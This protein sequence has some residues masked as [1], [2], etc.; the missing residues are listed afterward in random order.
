MCSSASWLS[1]PRSGR[2]ER[3]GGGIATHDADLR[4]ETHQAGEA[5]GAGRPAGVE[6]DRDDPAAA[7]AGQEARGPAQPGAEVEHARAGVDAGQAGEG[8]HRGQ[9]AVVILVELE[10]IVGGDR[11]VGERARAGAA[12][13]APG[14]R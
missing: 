11:R 7:P 9:A 8:V 10:E 6:L 3:Q 14:S 5:G 2:G 13:R 12:R 1:T 4:V